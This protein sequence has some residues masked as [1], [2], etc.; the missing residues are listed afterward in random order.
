MRSLKAVRSQVIAKVITLPELCPPPPVYPSYFQK[1][2]LLV[3]NMITF[4]RANHVTVVN[5]VHNLG[6]NLFSTWNNSL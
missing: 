4:L 1:R 5:V 3:S 2:R 6:S